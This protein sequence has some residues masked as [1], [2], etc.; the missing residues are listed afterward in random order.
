MDATALL[1]SRLQF[2]F[3]ISFHVIFPAFTIGLAA[4]L[5]VLE[6]LRLY[7]VGSSWFS[8]DEGKKG[9]LA[10]GQFADLTE[11]DGAVTP[12]LEFAPPVGADARR[13]S[14][15]VPEELQLEL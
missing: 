3:T 1:L 11:E 5:T 15:D 6:A 7:T 2:A 12:G 4:W 13:A 8:S 9:A 14:V 10:P